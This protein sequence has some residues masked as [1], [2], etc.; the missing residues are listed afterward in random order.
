M[1]R[2]RSDDKRTAILAAAVTLLAEQGLG[3]A[4]S[5]I[6]KA[7]GVA[8]GTLFIYFKTK[9]ALMNALYLAIKTELRDVMMAGYPGEGG[10]R[11][12]AHHVWTTYIDWGS[13]AP[14]K[15]RV[16]AQLGLSTRIDAQAKAEGAQAFAD[17]NAMLDEGLAQGVLR[18]HPPCFVAG[19]MGALADMTMDFMA[20]AP[21]EAERYSEAGFE[22]LWNAIARH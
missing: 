6:A 10:V 2:P 16:L 18:A 19:I 21:A 12:R 11:D 9:D 14:D 15:R 20:R 1:A 22:A 4:T 3:A 13:A 7:A 8:E 5:K 17:I